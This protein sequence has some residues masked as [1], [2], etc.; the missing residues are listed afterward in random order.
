MRGHISGEA[1]R[2]H[3]QTGGPGLK[4][5]ALDGRSVVANLHRVKGITRP[6][7]ARA[8]F[9][10]FFLGGGMRSLSA[11]RCKDTIAHHHRYIMENIISSLTYFASQRNIYSK[12]LGV[13]L[14]GL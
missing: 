9:P 3:A 11:R 2:E 8:V 1:C 5:S 6:D 4:E 14:K 13:L 10:A 7:S 12:F